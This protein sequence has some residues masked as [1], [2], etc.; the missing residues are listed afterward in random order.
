MYN[1]NNDYI[2]II[3][4]E[5]KK[6]KKNQ[7]KTNKQTNLNVEIKLS[8]LIFFMTHAE[9]VK[10]SLPVRNCSDRRRQLDVLSAK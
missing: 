10:G 2:H 3:W 1:L 4:R 6:R 5:K 7:R 8:E 9:K